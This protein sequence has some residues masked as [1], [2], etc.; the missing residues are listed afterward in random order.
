M[1]ASSNTSGCT[2]GNYGLYSTQSA[3]DVMDATGTNKRYLDAA[4]KESPNNQEEISS[5]LVETLIKGESMFDEQLEKFCEGQQFPSLRIEGQML[6]KEKE[7]TSEDF[8]ISGGG[9]KLLVKD[10][11]LA[12]IRDDLAEEEYQP[13]CRENQRRISEDRR[14]YLAEKVANA[15][16]DAA[17]AAERHWRINNTKLAA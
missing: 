10:E 6:S 17:A 7:K 9:T 3:S 4:T 8:G 14:K 1:D 11:F 12:A 16:A 13:L 5:N 2:T 15:T